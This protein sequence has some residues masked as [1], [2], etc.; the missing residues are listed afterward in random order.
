VV[1]DQ[2]QKHRTIR[3][4]PGWRKSPRRPI[5][6]AEIFL[7]KGLSRISRS[8]LKKGKTLDFF[9]DDDGR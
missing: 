5:K 4:A 1:R 8:P 7:S 9:S 2:P 6:P 3:I